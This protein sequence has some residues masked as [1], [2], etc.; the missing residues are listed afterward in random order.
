MLKLNNAQVIDQLK[1]ERITIYYFYTPLCG[2]CKLATT[3][4][5]VVSELL[6]HAPIVSCNI[7]IMPDIA[8]KFK[9]TSVPCLLIMKKENILEEVYSF[10]TTQYIYQLVKKYVD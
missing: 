2:T 9:I 6:P 8:Q 5:T 1:N 3:M 10:K 4:L 7:N